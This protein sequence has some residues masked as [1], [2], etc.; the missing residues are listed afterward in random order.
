LL[1]SNEWKDYELLD[2]GDGEKLERWGEYILRRPDPQIIWPRIFKENTWERAD[3]HY[4][5][6]K[7]GGGSWEHACTDADGHQFYLADATGKILIDAHAAEYDLPQTAERIV[8]SE[9]HSAFATS[10]GASDADLLKYISYAQMHRMGQAAS[11]WL[12]K[13]ID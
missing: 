8:N 7:N 4:I 2:T 11:E 9:S 3:G 5:R 12:E 6:S 13:R 1:I 10:S